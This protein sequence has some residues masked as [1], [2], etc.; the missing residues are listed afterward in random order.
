VFGRIFWQPSWTNFVNIDRFIGGGVPQVLFLALFLPVIFW[1]SLCSFSLDLKKMLNANGK[2]ENEF[3]EYKT[4]LFVCKIVNA[5]LISIMHEA[6]WSRYAITIYMRNASVSSHRILL[7][8]FL[9]RCV[10]MW[11]LPSFVQ[12]F[13]PTVLCVLI[14]SSIFLLNDVHVFD[15]CNLLI[16]GFHVLQEH[17]FSLEAS[18]ASAVVVVVVEPQCVTFRWTTLLNL[19]HHPL[20]CFQISL[21][22]RPSLD[23]SFWNSN[24]N[25]T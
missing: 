17:S 15:S 20:L 1:L 11:W 3:V 13:T 22:K 25:F 10:S 12:L 4:E 7:N 19:R 8:C 6:L 14:H 16:I 18:W 21:Q 2:Q 9:T 5:V 24:F 23:K